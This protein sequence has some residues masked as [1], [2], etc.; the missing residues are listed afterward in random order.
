MCETLKQTKNKT[1]YDNTCQHKQTNKRKVLKNVYK[2][3]SLAYL[4]LGNSFLLSG[5]K[6]KEERERSNTMYFNF[7]A[8]L[9]K[10]F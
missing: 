4:R 5:K 8:V 9:N 7:H 1:Q 6:K 2:T 3:L 10:A